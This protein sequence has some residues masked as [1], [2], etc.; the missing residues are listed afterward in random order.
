MLTLAL[1]GDSVTMLTLALEG[2]SVTMQ[3]LALEGDSVTMQTL[4]L[5]GDSVTNGKTIPQIDRIPN[6]C[7]LSKGKIYRSIQQI[8]VKYNIVVRII[9]Q[10]VS[11]NVK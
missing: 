1:E 8:K 5:D 9:Y 7:P 10:D 11:R 2:D 4:A 6:E 3:T